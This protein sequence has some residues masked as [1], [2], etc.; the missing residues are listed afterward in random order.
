VEG[1]TLGQGEGVSKNALCSMQHV[2]W[3]RRYHGAAL[4]WESAQRKKSLAGD[5][6]TSKSWKGWCGRCEGF[7][8]VQAELFA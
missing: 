6:S 3:T 4:L 7:E 2:L 8:G 5:A 1:R